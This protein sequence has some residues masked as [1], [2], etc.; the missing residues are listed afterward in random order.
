MCL[1]VSRSLTFSDQGLLI[2]PGFKLQRMETFE[3]VA[4]K[5]WNFLLL[6][7]TLHSTLHPT[8]TDG[9]LRPYEICALEN[10]Q[11]SYGAKAYR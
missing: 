2:V 10:G 8:D 5:L 7:K 6:D 9:R 1:Y 3:V 11:E 4:H